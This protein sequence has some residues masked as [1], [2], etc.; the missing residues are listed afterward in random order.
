[1]SF[2]DV[3]PLSLTPDCDRE[4]YNL[5]LGERNKCDSV[6]VCWN[7]GAGPGPQNATSFIAPEASC[8][9]LVCKY[10][11]LKLV[12]WKRHDI[13]NKGSS[14]GGNM[15]ILSL[16]E[17]HSWGN[18]VLANTAMALALSAWNFVPSSVHVRNEQHVK[19]YVAGGLQQLVHL[20][21]CL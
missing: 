8:H 11:T 12:N 10:A 2:F 6:V 1:M 3:S 18:A 14:R 20:S 7:I 15:P 16:Y 4:C 21:T 13:A 5:A 9:Q 17:E 19:T